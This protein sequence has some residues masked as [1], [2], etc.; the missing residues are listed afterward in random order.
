MGLVAGVHSIHSPYKTPVEIE[1]RVV[2][3]KNQTRLGRPK[4]ESL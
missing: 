3:A 2:E 4:S 1:D